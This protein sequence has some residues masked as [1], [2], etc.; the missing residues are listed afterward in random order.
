MKQKIVYI[1][2][3]VDDTQYHGSALNKETGELLSFRCRPTLNLRGFIHWIYAAT[4]PAALPATFDAS[5]G[6][7]APA[8]AGALRRNGLHYRAETGHKSHWTIQHYSWLRARPWI[9]AVFSATTTS[10]C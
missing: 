7:S 2:L 5:A 10:F 9:S 8:P 1:G 4:G 6:T 3:D